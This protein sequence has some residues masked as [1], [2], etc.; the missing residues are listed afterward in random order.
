[1]LQKPCCQ[2]PHFNFVRIGRFEWLKPG[3]FGGACRWLRNWDFN[4]FLVNQALKGNS[5][6]SSHF[7][8]IVEDVLALASSFGDTVWS[9]VK[10]S[11]KKITHEL[12]NFQP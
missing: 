10:H 1:M 9:F 8:R 11:G 7:H 4:S 3:C 6:G 12:I 5:R 2:A